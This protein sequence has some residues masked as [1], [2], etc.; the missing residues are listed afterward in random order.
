MEPPQQRTV[1]RTDDAGSTKL[2]ADPA[3]ESAFAV[4]DIDGE[5]TDV[6]DGST[7]IVSA[8]SGAFSHIKTSDARDGWIL[9]AYLTEE[10]PPPTQE[11]TQRAEELMPWERDGGAPSE[12]QPPA[13]PEPEPEPE[14]EPEPVAAPVAEP[15]PEP[16]AAEP[17]PEPAAASEQLAAEPEPAR[18][19]AVVQMAVDEDEDPDDDGMAH[20]EITREH[21]VAMAEELGL[22]DELLDS[23][24]EALDDDLQATAGMLQEQGAPEPW[25][26]LEAKQTT[27]AAAEA[28]AKAKSAAIATMAQG[29]VSK[30]APAPAPAAPAAAA[31]QDE[32]ALADK[33]L[34]P[35]H[36][37]EPAPAPAPAAAPAAAP[38]LED[39]LL[40]MKPYALVKR[41]VADRVDQAALEAAQDGETPREDII[42]LIIARAAE[43]ASKPK[44]RKDLLREFLE[45]R[46][47][48]PFTEAVAAA[49]YAAD[50]PSKGWINELDDIEVSAPLRC[51]SSRCP[52]WLYLA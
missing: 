35:A 21:L 33:Y 4:D 45:P 18:P 50:I 38:A 51:S 29:L 5:E 25:Q 20:R 1:R 6:S 40:A 43:V 11:E 27:A 46:G 41:A 47:Y 12:G 44:S 2:R 15:E 42:A 13:E 30:P 23:M 31:P 52:F 22:D 36:R 28:K 34:T 24:V 14:L 49:L 37:R 32:E 17:Q 26:A 48:A 8:V 16:V 3:D 10:Q 7:V 9:S 39:E 19:A